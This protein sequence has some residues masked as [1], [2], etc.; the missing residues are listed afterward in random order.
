[1]KLIQFVF[2]LVSTCNMAQIKGVVTDSLS[3]KP[4]PYVNIVVENENIGSTSEED[5]SFVVYTSEKSKR[6]LFSALGFEKKAVMVNEAKSVQLKPIEYQL[7]EVMISNRLQTKEIEIGKTNAAIR[8]AF[9]YGPRI[10]TKFFPYLPEYKKTKFIKQVSIVT[11]SKIETARI[12][13]HLYEVN[14]DGFPGKELI[15]KEL[16]VTIQ[17]G[18]RTHKI[19]ISKYN[20]VIPKKGLF[21]GF[22]KLL[23]ES[24]K[25]EKTIT[26]SNTKTTKI[27]RTYYPYVLYN[28]IERPFLFTFVGGKWIK[29]TNQN[30]EGVIEN[31]RMYE[32]S[33][34]I[35]LTN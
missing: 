32:P 8:Q 18:T 28:Y 22:E 27:V 25:V 2:L 13:I 14:D 1:M 7:Q 4:I 11:D 12:K 9:D 30:D 15:G 26:D 31:K 34:N 35:I 33:I 23:I 17:K 5:G 10:D 3:G 24:N 6:L 20:L 19:D 21:V 16:F 29:Q